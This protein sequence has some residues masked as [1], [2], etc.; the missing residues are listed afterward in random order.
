M[1]D[2]TRH[3]LIHQ[4]VSSTQEP[5]PQ[6]SLTFVRFRGVRNVTPTHH[7]YVSMWK[8]SSIHQ[9][10]K[11]VIKTIQSNQNHPHLHHPSKYQ[12][13]WCRPLYTLPLDTSTIKPPL[14]ISTTA[15]TKVST[16]NHK[17]PRIYPHPRHLITIGWK[18]PTSSGIITFLSHH[19][20]NLML[21]WIWAS[22]G[23]GG[24]C[25][26]LFEFK[27]PYRISS[28]CVILC[29]QSMSCCVFFYLS[30]FFNLI[31]MWFI[32]ENFEF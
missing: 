14:K 24:S 19:L 7:H 6:K 31:K 32:C 13:L 11:K 22:G 20:W 23:R 12:F 26:A 16:M 3:T 4:I 17:W 21:L 2:A 28:H 25:R 8:R 15:N 10:L 9:L 18:V 27:K 29:E 1:K 30:F 5:T